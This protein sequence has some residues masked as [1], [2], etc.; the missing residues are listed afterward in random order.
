M[1]YKLRKAPGR[2]LYWVVG[3][4]GSHKSKDP[5][6]KKRAMAQMRAL[7]ANVK[8]IKGGAKLSERGLASY[9]REKYYFGPEGSPSYALF[10][11]LSAV[12][13]SP[14]TKP[15]PRHPFSSLLEGSE[16]KADKA[17]AEIVGSNGWGRYVKLNSR[18]G[19]GQQGFS[20][21]PNVPPPAG[22]SASSSASSSAGASSLAPPSVNPWTKP[23]GS[24]RS[25]NVLDPGAEAW[26]PPEEHTGLSLPV[27][28]LGLGEPEGEPEGEVLAE[29]VAR[30]A[31][32]PEP[33]AQ[34]PKADEP[35]KQ[36][37]KKQKKEKAKK[38][39]FD[40]LL[41]E[42][43]KA[44][45]LAFFRQVKDAWQKK[46]D[47]VS[48]YDLQ[49]TVD[50]EADKVDVALAKAR[51]KERE[52]TALDKEREPIKSKAERLQKEIK[53]MGEAGEASYKALKAYF[54]AIEPL[55]KTDPEEYKR[56]C[57]A[58]EGDEKELVKMSV[59]G[60]RKRVELGTVKSRFDAIN[61]TVRIAIEELEEIG[62]EGEQADKK[63]KKAQTD[64]AKNPDY[65]LIDILRQKGWIDEYNNT[66]W[67][68]KGPYKGS[69][70]RPPNDILQK[71]AVQSYKP[72]PERVIG[73][74][75][76]FRTS[77]TLKFYKQGN[78]VVVGIRGTVPSDI[79]DVK[80]DGL[81]ALNQLETSPR[82]Q[83]DVALMR[84]VKNSMP[85]YDFYGVGHSL[86][87]A[88]LDGL[89]REN[90]LLSGVSYNPA[91]QPKDFNSNLPNSRIYQ[92]G[93]PLYALGKN[94]LKNAPEVREDKPQSW[95]DKLIGL[96]PYAGKVYN[97]LNAHNL[98]NFEG[99]R[100]SA[101]SPTPS[102]P[103]SREEYL[104]RVRE[105][106]KSE[107]YPYKLLGYADDDKHKF[108]IPNQEGKIIRFGRKGYGDFL[109]WSALEASGKVAKGY[110]LGKRRDLHNSHNKIKGHWR[111]D[112]FSPNNLALKILW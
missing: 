20:V 103:L 13:H 102:N 67:E 46:R 49:N 86:G 10:Q 83:K 84:Q 56:L 91:V 60:E 36:K 105:K 85:R 22:A 58:K 21:V 99:G 30:G 98:S 77:P 106:A 112:L 8:D 39:D 95:K 47:G 18:W 53:E 4:D 81:I 12:V 62:R 61:S 35:P 100:K 89:L 73:D 44:S 28:D 104:S 11:F 68:G 34:P 41:E 69:G 109:I 110:A 43:N 93:D 24:K 7:Y 3:E 52:I 97:Y 70:A 45:K 42:E 79:E 2:D 82:F 74:F 96:V 33:V 26:E 71:I 17:L 5:I 32:P 48:L 27:G 38:E 65:K 19:E 92:K 80:A 94:F 108:Q 54:N 66:E 87:G 63:Q 16:G 111:S 1:P 90:L 37:A 64:M 23:A 50:E 76:L 51:A 78:T 72:N 59:D 55:N 75:T 14:D 40:S 88:V 107:G 57:K 15:M 9:L 31:S 6:P 25:A 101:V 29:A